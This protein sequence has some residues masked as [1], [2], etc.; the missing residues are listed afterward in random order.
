[1]TSFKI[2]LVINTDNHIPKNHPFGGYSTKVVGVKN[3]SPQNSKAQNSTK[4]H[5]I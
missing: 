5:T 4:W 3:H 1:M 2:E